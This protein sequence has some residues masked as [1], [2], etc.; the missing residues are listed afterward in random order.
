MQVARLR[1]C[2]DDRNNNIACV[3]RMKDSPKILGLRNW[4]GRV[5]IS[6]QIYQKSRGQRWGTEFELFNKILFIQ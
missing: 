5:V 6:R 3:Q 1:I 4:K 2:I